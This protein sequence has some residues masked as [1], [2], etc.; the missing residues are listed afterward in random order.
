MRDAV[1]AAP[2]A[3]VTCLSRS[4]SGSCMGYLDSSSVVYRSIVPVRRI[5]RCSSS[6]P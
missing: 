5:F 2:S 3:V 1:T 6:T 4:L